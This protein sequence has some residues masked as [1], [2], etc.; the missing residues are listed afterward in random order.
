MTTGPKELMT[1]W[2]ASVNARDWPG[3]AAL[4]GKDYSFQDTRA[5][6]WEGVIGPDQVAELPKSFLTV[7][8]D[9][10]VAFE[11]LDGDD[12]RFATRI[13]ATGAMVD[14]GGDFEWSVIHVAHVENGK[15]QGTEVFDPDDDARALARL[16]E[17][18]D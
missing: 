13:L 9:F 15:F 6:G 2:C 12:Q 16:D 17:L 11:W 1:A 8:Q 3:V 7:S 5:L 14:G 10:R 18:S 4:F